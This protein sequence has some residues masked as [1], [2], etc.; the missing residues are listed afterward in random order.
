[1]GVLPG[2]GTAGGSE[3]CME[4][5]AL[6]GVKTLPVWTSSVQMQILSKIHECSTVNIPATLPATIPSIP[7]PLG[8]NGKAL[9]LSPWRRGVGASPPKSISEISSFLPWCLARATRDP[10]R[11]KPGTSLLWWDQ[12]RC[13]PG[14]RQPWEVLAAIYDHEGSNRQE[15]ASSRNVA[16]Q[17][18]WQDGAAEAFNISQIF[19]ALT[20]SFL[21][22]QQSLTQFL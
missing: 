20:S 12:M 16:G 6:P 10:I 14:R 17:S 7:L 15:R 2:A 19:T 18:W 22:F 4:V 11:G 9:T 1:M 3:T 21:I 5:G 8:S 13:L